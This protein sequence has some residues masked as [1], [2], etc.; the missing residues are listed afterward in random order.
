M[1][2]KTIKTVIP[3]LSMPDKEKGDNK[4]SSKIEEQK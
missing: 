1:L 4:N 2:F 3:H